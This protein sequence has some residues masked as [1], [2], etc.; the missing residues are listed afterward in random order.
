MG[1]EEVFKVFLDRVHA[2]THTGAPA[3]DA[4]AT[5]TGVGGAGVA[6]RAHCRDEAVRGFCHVILLSGVKNDLWGLSGDTFMALYHDFEYSTRWLR[7]PRWRKR[8]VYF[9]ATL[10]GAPS[11]ECASVR[12]HQETGLG[13]D[14]LIWTPRF[15]VYQL[16]TPGQW[17]RAPHKREK[18]NRNTN[19]SD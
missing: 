1:G 11:C 16:F 5:L 18:P 12:L 3:G 10:P 9:M 4:F 17:A 14:L 19:V 6:L 15:S 2:L 7:H 8:M 13:T